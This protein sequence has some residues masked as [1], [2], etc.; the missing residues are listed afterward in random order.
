MILNKLNIVT[1]MKVTGETFSFIF[2][3]KGAEEA[4]YQKYQNFQAKGQSKSVI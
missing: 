1:C 3:R 2:E 4:R